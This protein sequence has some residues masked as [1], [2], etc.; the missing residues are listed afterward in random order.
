MQCFGKEASSKT[1]ELLTGESVYLEIDNPTNIVDKYGRLLR[2]VYRA[3]DD[4][5]INRYLV[6]E[7]FAHEYTYQGQP[8]K[9]QTE[10]RSA[11]AAARAQ[12]LGL[13]DTNVCP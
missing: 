11:E 9:Y 4:L 13:W 2:Y 6:E 3:K 7:G 1:K 5:F 12:N 10:F 8:H